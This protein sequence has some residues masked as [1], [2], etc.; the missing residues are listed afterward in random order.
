[1][2][3]GQYKIHL[4]LKKVLNPLW[5]ALIPWQASSSPVFLAWHQTLLIHI[6]PKSANVNNLTM[7]T[8]LPTATK[9]I[10]KDLEGKKS[11]HTRPRRTPPSQ[12][13]HITSRCYT[14]RCK[15]VQKSLY[16]L[17][18]YL[19]IQK[20]TSNFY[21][22]YISRIF[23]RISKIYLIIYFNSMRGNGYEVQND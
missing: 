17:L 3:T 12:Q 4:T 2:K 21:P 11:F 6:I 20:E 5:I 22:G 18:P 10:R 7:F 13:P 15:F 23:T 19:C 14:E 8:H 16:F 9:K 1:M